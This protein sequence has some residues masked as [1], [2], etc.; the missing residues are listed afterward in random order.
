MD[1]T[2]CVWITDGLFPILECEVFLAI[3]DFWFGRNPKF[4]IMIVTLMVTWLQIRVFY[5]SCT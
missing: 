4:A 3:D 2:S 1:S 5:V